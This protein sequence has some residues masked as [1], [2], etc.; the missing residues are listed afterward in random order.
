MN[1]HYLLHFTTIFY[2]ILD[3]SV[4]LLNWLELLF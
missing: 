3:A 1:F 4:I 2:Q